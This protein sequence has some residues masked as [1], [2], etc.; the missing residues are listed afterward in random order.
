MNSRTYVI[1][2]PLFLKYFINYRDLW[3]G[4][5]L[6]RNCSA[7]GLAF[8]KCLIQMLFQHGFVLCIVHHTIDWHQFAT[9]NVWE[10][11]PKHFYW[12]FYC[13]VNISY[14]DFTL[15]LPDVSRPMSL[16]Y[17]IC[18]ISKQNVFQSCIDTLSLCFFM[19]LTNF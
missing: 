9:V 12:M 17:E 11:H 19:R 1:V 16:N 2:I 8:F 10:T 15:K 3:Q 13:L 4:A 14:S 18:F 5:V 6:L 7:L